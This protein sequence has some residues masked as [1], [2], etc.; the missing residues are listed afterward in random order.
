[1][2]I[3]VQW[4]GQK[5]SKPTPFSAKRIFT[6]T[7]IFLCIVLIIHILVLRLLHWF[8]DRSPLLF[9]DN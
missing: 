9:V 8:V 4:I 1:M 7:S 2:G 5:Q 3:G 6:N